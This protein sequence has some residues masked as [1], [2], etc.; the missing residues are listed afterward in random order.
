MKVNYNQIIL[1]FLIFFLFSSCR[2]DKKSQDKVITNIIIENFKGKD[3]KLNDIVSGMRVLP[4]KLSSGQLIG[5][6]KDIC[7]IDDTI[8]VL[9]A[10][11][12][13]IFSFDRT[14]GRCI[15][16][17]CNKGNGPN[18]YINPVSLSACSQSLYV[19]DL[20]TSRIIEFDKDLNAIKSLRFNFPASDFI[21]I[22][23][24]FL[25]YNLAPDDDIKK[26]VHIDNKGNTLNSFISS[27]RNQPTSGYTGGLGKHF[28]RDGTGRVTA[29]ESYSNSIYLWEHNNL[30]LIHQIDFKE[31]NI[32]IGI[33][34]SRINIFE[35]PYVFNSNYFI[36]SDMLISSFLYKMKRYY[37]VIS[38]SSENRKLG[39]V[40]EEQYNIPFFPQWQNK[41]QLIGVCPYESI[42]SY[43]EDK[44]KN[45]SFTSDSYDP[46]NPVLLFF[47]M[48]S[49]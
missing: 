26:F 43:M 38:L 47:N 28:I 1:A 12:G 35:D 20:P 46:E 49:L 44:E 32:P 6:V 21:A 7:F 9:D 27:D 41:E 48:T 19:L 16:S 37:G 40:K 11:T 2:N 25:L 45:N 13:T 39:I 5:Q 23:S 30:K 22:D 36:I 3:I 33:D 8:Y 42:E 4:L 31:L 24:G 29:S 10:I 15:G 34:K 17:S 14:S 18:E